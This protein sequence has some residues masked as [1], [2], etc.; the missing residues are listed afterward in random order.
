MTEIATVHE[1]TEDDEMGPATDLPTIRR[2][3]AADPEARGVELAE[4]LGAT[5]VG[6]GDDAAGAVQ[7]RADAARVLESYGGWRASATRVRPESVARLRELAVELGRALRV[8][9]NTEAA[10][11]ASVVGKLSSGTGVAVHPAALRA[12][13]QAVIRTEHAVA[14]AQ[15]ALAELGERPT[16]GQAGGSRP[17][18]VR[19]QVPEMMDD[20]ALDAAQTR[21]RAIAVGVAIVGATL[22]V[23]GLGWVPVLAAPVGALVALI[24]GLV[25][26][27]RGQAA[28]ADA[29]DRRE[30]SDALLV[31]AAAADRAAEAVAQTRE[32]H[33]VWY[34]QRSRLDIIFERVTGEHR[35]ALRAWEALAGPEADPYDLDGVLRLHDPQFDVAGADLDTSPTIRTVSAMHRKALARWRV[36]WAAVGED[37]PPPPDESE[38]DLARLEATALLGTPLVLVCPPAHVEDDLNA[39]PLGVP[40]TV[41]DY[42]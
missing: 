41:V 16:G 31:A 7:A 25:I 1:H 20:D 11:T 35:A 13:A 32:A 19:R 23:V 38:P 30:A 3:F 34:D 39:L 21:T 27:R 40:I 36:S 22:V 9:E 12:A 8:R 42:Q 5:L 28:R 26:L 6:L 14:N 2:E 24:V 18:D 37:N 17:A 10:V 4:E 15:E 29:A 33:D